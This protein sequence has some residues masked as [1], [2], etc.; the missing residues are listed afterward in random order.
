MDWPSSDNEAPDPDDDDYGA[1]FEAEEMYD[2]TQRYE[3]PARHC[4]RPLATP[5]APLCRVILSYP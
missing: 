4:V 5:R 1:E 3:I 2:A